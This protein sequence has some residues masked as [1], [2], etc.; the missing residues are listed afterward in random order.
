MQSLQ[1]SHSAS[2]PF[3]L[4]LRLKKS[5]TQSS[6]RPWFPLPFPGISSN[7]SPLLGLILSA[8]LGTE[9]FQWL[10]IALGL[11][12]QALPLSGNGLLLEISPTLHKLGL[13]MKEGFD[14]VKCVLGL[15][16]NTH[17]LCRLCLLTRVS[18]ILKATNQY[19]PLGEFSSVSHSAL[20]CYLLTIHYLHCCVQCLPYALS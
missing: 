17:A 7:C 20:L 12:S 1:A 11:A 16:L 13:Q 3:N 10:L 15:L 14:Y 19:C 4:L 8:S 2:G 18:V 5:S 9:T 6:Y